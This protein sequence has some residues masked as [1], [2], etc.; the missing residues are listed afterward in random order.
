VLQCDFLFCLIQIDTLINGEPIINIPPKSI[1]LNKIE[2]TPEERAFY[3]R[4]EERSRQQFKVNL[5]SILFYE[6]K[7]EAFNISS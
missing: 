4:L 7:C 5:L 2:F 6:L 3:V 1:C